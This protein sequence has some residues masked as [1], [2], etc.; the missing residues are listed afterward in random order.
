MKL[1]NKFYDLSKWIVLVFL[2]ALSVLVGS[3]SKLYSWTE[4]SMLMGTINLL[5]VFLGSLLQP[6][7]QKYNNSSHDLSG[8]IENDTNDSK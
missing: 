8:G 3:L 1:S 5:T 7:S 6:S 2:P 4:A